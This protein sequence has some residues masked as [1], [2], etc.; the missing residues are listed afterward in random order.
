MAMYP[1]VPAAAQ[2]LVTGHSLGGA[3]ATLAAFDIARS[4][5][6]LGI[7]KEQVM[8]TTFGAPRTGNQAFAD[9]FNRT[10]TGGCWMLV[11]DQARP[12][13]EPASRWDSIG[14]VEQAMTACVGMKLC[15]RHVPAHDLHGCN[16]AALRCAGR[17]AKDRE[18]CAAVCKAWAYGHPHRA[19]RHAR[20]VRAWRSRSDPVGRISNGCSFRLAA[21]LLPD[22]P[23]A[24]ACHER[25]YA[26]VIP[27][28]C[29]KGR[30]AQPVQPDCFV[31]S[32]KSC[33]AC[34]L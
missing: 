21:S 13:P 31:Q 34:C 11:N 32:I 17:S 25:P 7:A 4:A 27:K 5:D 15:W 8:C 22:S 24:T 3:V 20:Q 1:E 26:T 30:L 9:L 33:K 18:V 6:R 29:C 14:P 12:M 10:V 23:R 16:I 2:I 28:I 19:R